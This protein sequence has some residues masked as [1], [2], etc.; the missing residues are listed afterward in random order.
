MKP[1]SPGISKYSVPVLT[2]RKAEWLSAWAASWATRWSSSGSERSANSRLGD[3]RDMRS[4]PPFVLGR[5]VLS[6][7]VGTGEF[8]IQRVRFRLEGDPERLQHV[9]EQGPVAHQ[10][11]WQRE[12]RPLRPDQQAPDT[13]QRRRCAEVMGDV[14]G[15]I[16]RPRHLAVPFDPDE[17][18]W[19]VTD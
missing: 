16:E 3:G 15:H 5:C 6:G 12:Q 11:D 10:V 7:V 14:V 17:K 4:R 1:S 2:A 8:R 13:G 19:Q 18:T 9:A